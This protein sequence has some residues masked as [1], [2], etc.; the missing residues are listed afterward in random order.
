M[1]YDSY[2]SSLLVYQHNIEFPPQDQQFH[3]PGQSKN[4]VGGGIYINQWLH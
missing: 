2:I 1:I 3:P 4:G